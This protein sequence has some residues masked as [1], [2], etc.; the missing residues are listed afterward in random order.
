VFTLYTERDHPVFTL[1][2]MR[3]LPGLCSLVSWAR[4]ILLYTFAAHV[5]LYIIPYQISAEQSSLDSPL[6][7]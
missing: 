1:C 7:T 2:H 5:R 6:D 4:S 3:M